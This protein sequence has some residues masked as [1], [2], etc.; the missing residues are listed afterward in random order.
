MKRIYVVTK[1]QSEMNFVNKV[2]APF[3]LPSNKNLIPTTVLTKV[4]E[5]KGNMNRTNFQIHIKRFRV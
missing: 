2:L 5:Q 3:F 1:A 4:D